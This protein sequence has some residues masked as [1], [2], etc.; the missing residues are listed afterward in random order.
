MPRIKKL[1]EAED[2]EPVV[3]KRSARLLQRH[4]SKCKKPASAESLLCG[5]CTERGKKKLP[6]PT[7]SEAELPKR[8]LRLI[9]RPKSADAELTKPLIEDSDAQQQST[10]AVTTPIIKLRM[11]DSKDPDILSESVRTNDTP[12]RYPPAKK[13]VKNKRKRAYRTG[14]IPSLDHSFILDAVEAVE[15]RST[16]NSLTPARF[17]S[18]TRWAEAHFNALKER[19]HT[20]QRSSLDGFSTF[21][22]GFQQYITVAHDSKMINSK[23]SSGMIITGD[24]VTIRPSPASGSLPPIVFFARIIAVYLVRSTGQGLIALQWLLPRGGQYW[25]LIQ[26]GIFYPECF[27]D[28]TSYLSFVFLGPLHEQLESVECIG[29]VFFRPGKHKTSV[30]REHFRGEMDAA[31]S[32]LSLF[33]KENAGLVTK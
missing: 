33:S 9:S 20:H 5:E 16:E 25:R 27:I 6:S 11:N 24:H 12:Q 32:L 2:K 23:S 17:Y 21:A 7:F 1:K 13:L 29:D 18:D 10:T 19:F 14:S 28:G 3:I 4:C 31:A 26:Q 15:Q 8:Q 30:D 22:E